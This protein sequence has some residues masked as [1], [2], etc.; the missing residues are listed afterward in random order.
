M[1]GMT[2]K[3]RTRSIVRD[4]VSVRANDGVNDPTVGG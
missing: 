4:L 3:E 2:Y 1:A